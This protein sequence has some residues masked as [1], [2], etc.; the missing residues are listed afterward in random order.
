MSKFLALITKKKYWYVHSFFIKIILRLFYGIKVGKKF[1]IEGIPLLKINGKGD[2]IQIGNNVSIMGDVDLRNRENGKIIIGNNVKIDNYCRLVAAND[3]VLKI[4]NNTNIG[5]FTIIN[6]GTD[7]TIGDKC[8]ISGLIQI[9][10]S[11][12]GIAKGTP[13][14]E[15]KHTYEKINIGNDVWLAANCTILKGVTLEDGCIVGAKSLVRQGHYQKNSI[16][17]GIPA[18]KVKERI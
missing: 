17:A 11:D 3:A 6:C 18:K 8:M 2:N 4:G 13:I 7:V 9:Q 16:L 10:S 1:Y 15:Q 12:H 5:A 14:R